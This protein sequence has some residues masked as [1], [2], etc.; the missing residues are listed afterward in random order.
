M[1]HRD[2]GDGRPRESARAVYHPLRAIDE[3]Q[4][5]E[6]LIRERLPVERHTPRNPTVPYPPHTSPPPPPPPPP[7]PPPTSSL[8]PRLAA[9]LHMS[10]ARGAVDHPAMANAC[11]LWR[12]IIRNAAFVVA[13][14]GAEH[15]PSRLSSQCGGGGRTRYHAQPR[16]SPER[17]QVAAAR[18]AAAPD[19]P[20]LRRRVRWGDLRHC[21]ASHPWPWAGIIPVGRSVSKPCR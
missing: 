18:A 9:A 20:P 7:T 5:R 12:A 13:R 14:R 4:G 11:K 6:V 3:K 15:A 2:H 17:R 10:V 16:L 19:G 21:W 8:S 1:W